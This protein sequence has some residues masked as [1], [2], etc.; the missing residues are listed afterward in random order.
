MQSDWSRVFSITTQELD[1]SQPCHFDRFSKVVHHLKSKN[2]IDGPNILSKPVL[3]IF[4][5]ILRACLTKPKENCMI[6]L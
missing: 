5:R 6:K 1:F 3:L 2:H 4:F